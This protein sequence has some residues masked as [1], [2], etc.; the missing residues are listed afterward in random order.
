MDDKDEGVSEEFKMAVEKLS[1]KL[2]PNDKENNALWEL[3]TEI[4][5]QDEDNN[6]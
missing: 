6:D 2:E 5:Q 4:Y 1:K 3:V